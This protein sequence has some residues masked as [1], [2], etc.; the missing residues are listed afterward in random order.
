LR[1]LPN[2]INIKKNSPQKWGV[3]FEFN[4]NILSVKFLHPGPKPPGRT[5]SK[6]FCNA[7][8]QRSPRKPLKILAFFPGTERQNGMSRLPRVLG[9]VAV[10]L[11][12]LVWVMVV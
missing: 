2:L 12:R 11:F 7:K 4:V 5:K 1:H 3:L 10:N 9:G 6:N 8:A